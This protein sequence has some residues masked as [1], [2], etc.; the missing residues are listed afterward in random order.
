MEQIF[1]VNNET[2]SAAKKTADLDCHEGRLTGSYGEK[3]DCVSWWIKTIRATWK[4]PLITF[5][6]PEKQKTNL[7]LNLRQEY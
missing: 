7:N 4:F 3:V 1:A 6:I 5:L 2:T